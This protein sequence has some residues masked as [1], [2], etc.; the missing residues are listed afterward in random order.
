VS[1]QAVPLP[2]PVKANIRVF[3]FG[4]RYFE[5]LNPKEEI[6]GESKLWLL[7]WKQG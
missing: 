6:P 7:C 2:H 4:N 3:R 1:P 5:N